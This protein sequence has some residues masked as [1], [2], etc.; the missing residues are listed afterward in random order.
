LSTKGEDREYI[1]GNL[2]SLVET[3]EYYADK[4]KGFL[5]IV[6]DR[7]DELRFIKKADK[8]QVDK[9][10]APASAPAESNLTNP[11]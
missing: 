11:K 3:V 7:M 6:S 10:E 5:T 1:Y 4:H 9:A 2:K 8:S